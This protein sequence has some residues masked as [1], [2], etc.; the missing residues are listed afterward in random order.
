MYNGI[1]TSTSD[2]VCSAI[3]SSKI[4]LPEDVPVRSKHVVNI[5]TLMTCETFL[6]SILANKM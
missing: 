3:A 6:T 5:Y 4:I 2:N 1:I